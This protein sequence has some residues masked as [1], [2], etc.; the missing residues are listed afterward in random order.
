MTW[1]QIVARDAEF[2]RDVASDGAFRVET[3]VDAS[4][5]SA[6]YQRKLGLGMSAEE[7]ARSALPCVLVWSFATHVRKAKPPMREVLLALACSVREATAAACGGDN[8]EFGYE[9]ELEQ[10]VDAFLL[11][12]GEVVG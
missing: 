10:M 7:V 12:D 6:E 8:E 4:R 1:A 2:L 11:Y 3:R 9:V 5:L